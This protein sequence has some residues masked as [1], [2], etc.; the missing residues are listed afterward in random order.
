LKKLFD[1]KK[2]E[3]AF[4]NAPNL[5]NDVLGDR[6]VENIQEG[7]IGGYVNQ[8]GIVRVFFRDQF[9]KLRSF[10]DYSKAG[11]IDDVETIVRFSD[12]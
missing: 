1:E 11:K 3:I 9:S 4:K 8:W 6:K 7:S 10:L 12:G 2:I 5:T